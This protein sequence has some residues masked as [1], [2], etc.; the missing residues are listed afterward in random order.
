VAELA[1]EDFTASIRY[2]RG[3]TDKPLKLAA[4]LR[5]VQSLCE[6]NFN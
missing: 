2:V 5:I 1:G 6:W 4:L 3:M